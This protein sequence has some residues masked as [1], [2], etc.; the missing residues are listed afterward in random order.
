MP[1]SIVR[2]G[3]AGWQ[4]PDWEGVI[5]PTEKPHGFE[6][7]E[8]IARLV[9]VVE[10]N[11]SYYAPVSPNSARKWIRIVQPASGFKF[12]A[13]LW[14]RFTHEKESWGDEE[15]SIFQRG[16]EPLLNSGLL[17]C[18]LCQFPWAFRESK[19]NFDRLKKIARDFKGWPL[20]VELRHQ[21]WMKD[22]LSDWLKQNQIGFANI[23]QPLFHDSM[24]P[25]EIVTSKIGY[26]RLHGRNYKTWF[27]KDAETWERYDYL[28]EKKELEEWNARVKK[29]AR[30]TKQLFVIVNNH[31][32]GKEV[33][34]TLMLKFMS[35]GK[36]QK[37]PKS[38][39]AKYS[40]LR[41][42]CAPM[43][44]QAELF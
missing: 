37:A 33:A 9:D 19:D 36:K 10:I 22:K 29:I 2:F 24:P 3:V 38:L 34:N 11:S 15:V 41:E 40:T 8:L 35:T 32:K 28:Y 21:S 16:L 26:I 1:K 44:K 25:T 17:G 18:I 6:P 39:I 31:Y 23:D 43:E 5:Y 27:K 20:A 30:Q 13:K 4:Y 42:C 12:S 7:L 14:Q